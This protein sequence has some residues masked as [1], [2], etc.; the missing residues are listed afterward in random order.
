MIDHCCPRAAELQGLGNLRD[1]F[2]LP[3]GH[4]TLSDPI[5]HDRDME[6]SGSHVQKPGH[7]CLRNWP[8]S[9]PS[10]AAMGM[11]LSGESGGS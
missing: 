3:L 9:P 10:Q 5:N 4:I 8:E 11:D 1:H 6:K 7:Q 2:W